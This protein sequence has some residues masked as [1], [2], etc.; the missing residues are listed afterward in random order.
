MPLDPDYPPQRIASMVQ[1]TTC[2][3][4]VTRADLAS[5]LPRTSGVPVRGRREARS[6]RVT[7]TAQVVPW[8]MPAMRWGG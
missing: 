1:G 7:R 2:A 5:R 8:T 6:A 3:V 4:L